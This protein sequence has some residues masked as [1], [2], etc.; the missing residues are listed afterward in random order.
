MKCGW[1]FL[2]A[3][4]IVVVI[5]AIWVGVTALIANSDLPEWLKFALIVRR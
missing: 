3:I 4:V 1:I 5:L 2:R